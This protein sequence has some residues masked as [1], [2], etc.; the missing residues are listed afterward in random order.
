MVKQGAHLQRNPNAVAVSSWPRL[1]LLRGCCGWMSWPG[2]TCCRVLQVAV[3]VPPFVWAPDADW[4]EPSLYVIVALQRC[5]L[6]A[7]AG[8]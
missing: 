7:G 6:D 1:F 3:G 2:C 8:S 5:K 4:F